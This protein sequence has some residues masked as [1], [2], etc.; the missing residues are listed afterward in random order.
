V[1]PVRLIA[2]SFLILAASAS[3]IDVD[4]VLSRSELRE[5]DDVVERAETGLRICL[6]TSLVCVASLSRCAGEKTSSLRT[7]TLRPSLVV[8]DEVEMEESLSESDELC[9]LYGEPP[10]LSTPPVAISFFPEIRSDTVSIDLTDQPLSPLKTFQADGSLTK[11][12]KLHGLHKA[13]SEVR[14][15]SLLH[16]NISTP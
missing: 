14:L 16:W 15:D 11:N 13:E 2:C 6:M 10:G 5:V 9:E 12:G 4:E 7:E 3:L 8:D 1:S